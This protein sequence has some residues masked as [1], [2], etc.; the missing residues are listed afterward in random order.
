M[1]F[2]TKVLN[3]FRLVF[4]SLKFKRKSFMR[5]DRD[6][7]KLIYAYQTQVTIDESLSEIRKILEKFK[8]KGF[9]Y[10]NN[11]FTN[12]LYI[13]FT[14]DVKNIGNVPVRIDIPQFYC[15]GKY[16]EKPSYRAMVM[17]VKSKL[18]QVDL[19]EPIEMVF[20]PNIPSNVRLKLLPKTNDLPMLKD[21]KNDDR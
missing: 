13:A 10:V 15:N 21:D 19:G 3:I 11:P 7:L 2:H 14:I 16:L 12:E 4:V 17:L 5:I 9:A 1:I 6:N 18:T 20:L 8:C